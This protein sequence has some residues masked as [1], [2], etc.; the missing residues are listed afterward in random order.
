MKVVYECNCGWKGNTL[1]GLQT[2]RKKINKYIVD[3]VKCPKCKKELNLINMLNGITNYDAQD[4]DIYARNDAPTGSGGNAHDKAGVSGCDTERGFAETVRADG[5][6]PAEICANLDKRHGCIRGGG[7]AGIT[8]QNRAEDARPD[9]VKTV[10]SGAWFQRRAYIWRIRGRDMGQ[11]FK[12]PW[13][14]FSGRAGPIMAQG[15]QPET[16]ILQRGHDGQGNIS[17]STAT[18][19]ND[20]GSAGLLSSNAAGGYAGIGGRSGSEPTGGSGWGRCGRDGPKL[21]GEGTGSREGQKFR[22]GGDI[23][24]HNPG[25]SYVAPSRATRGAEDKPGCGNAGTVFNSPER[26]PDSTDSTKHPRHKSPTD[27]EHLH[28]ERVKNSYRM[29]RVEGVGGNG[30]LQP[31]SRKDTPGERNKTCSGNARAYE[32]GNDA[33]VY[34]TIRAGNPRKYEGMER[35][36]NGAIQCPNTGRNATGATDGKLR[37]MGARGYAHQKPGLPSEINKGQMPVYGQVRVS[38]IWE[39]YA[40]R[41]LGKQNERD[42]IAEHIGGL[43]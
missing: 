21:E 38:H 42:Y 23:T 40:S 24:G 35:Q 41:T 8:P 29:A 10:L 2:K 39:Q 33:V 9:I 3:V 4:S 6:N 22:N 14:R 13:A 30:V 32:H 15:P 27:R 1:K 31:H 28:G 20:I 11:V 26:R 43:F 7:N 19:V 18:G 12:T 37:L 25:I 5:P 16:A 36:P 34:P 17:H